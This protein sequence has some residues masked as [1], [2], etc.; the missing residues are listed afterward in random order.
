[1]TNVTQK[2][3]FRISFN[4]YNHELLKDA[5]IM[6]IDK[7]KKLDEIHNLKSIIKG[8][9]HLPIKKRYYSVIR[10]PHIDKDSHEQFEIRTHKWIL[11]FETQNLN[12]INILG[13]LNI[14]SGIKINIIVDEVL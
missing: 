10:S 13:L 12:Y 3:K 9:I 7:I 4:A 1:M 8:P 5:I 11:D 14:P 2:L 6:V